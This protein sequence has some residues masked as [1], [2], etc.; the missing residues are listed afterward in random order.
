MQVLSGL[1]YEQTPASA[2]RSPYEVKRVAGIMSLQSG[3]RWPY[4]PAEES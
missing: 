2:M 4:S 3:R 1:F